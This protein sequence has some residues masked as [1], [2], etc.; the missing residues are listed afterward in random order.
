M[1]YFAEYPWIA[2]RCAAYHHTIYTITILIFNSF[3]RAVYISVTK[4]GYVYPWVVFNL[5]NKRPVGFT[6]IHLFA[7][8]TMYSKRFYA[9]IL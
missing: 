5:G 8:T 3:L 1:F 2:N 7:S 6:F 4:Y 9:N